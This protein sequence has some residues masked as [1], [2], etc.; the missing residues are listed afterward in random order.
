MRTKP[1]VSRAFHSWNGEEKGRVWISGDGFKCR[2]S[3]ILIKDYSLILSKMEEKTNKEK[4]LKIASVQAGKDTVNLNET[5]CCYFLIHSFR[6]FNWRCLKSLK[7]W[8]NC[9][10]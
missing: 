1:D 4:T 8:P 10:S 2:G 5:V 3:E 7:T 6:L 9:A